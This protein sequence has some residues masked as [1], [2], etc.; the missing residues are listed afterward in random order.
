MGES[1]GQGS[2]KSWLGGADPSKLERGDRF[3]ER[4]GRQQGQ[5]EE[6]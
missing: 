3:L 1:Q 6:L 2:Q 4:T 5:P